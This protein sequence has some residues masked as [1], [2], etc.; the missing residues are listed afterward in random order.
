M[1]HEWILQKIEEYRAAYME[2]LAMAN[3]NHGAMQALEEALV[4]WDRQAAEQELA[5]E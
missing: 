2:H 4:E 1:K 3:A 5:D